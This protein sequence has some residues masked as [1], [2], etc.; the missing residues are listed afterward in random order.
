MANEQLLIS[1]IEYKIRKLIEVN[2][3]VINENKIL[4][5]Q[6][7]KLNEKVNEL[8]GSLQEA[9]ENI[10]K[11]TLANTLEY[12]FGVEKGKEKLEGLIQEIDRCIDVLSE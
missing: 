11:L 3:A 10:V 5:Q 2:K 1:A 8:T 9:K 7:S 4:K 6:V 12:N